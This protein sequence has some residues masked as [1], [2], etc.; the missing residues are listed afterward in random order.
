MCFYFYN[1]Q[2]QRRYVPPEKD[3]SVYIS[4]LKIIAHPHL[5]Q[6]KQLY[7]ILLQLVRIK[8]RYSQCRSAIKKSFAYVLCC[9]SEYTNCWRSSCYKKKP[10]SVEL[11]LKCLPASKNFRR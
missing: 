1:C 8:H 11:F 10:L 3:R 5:M 6:E 9:W 4:F 7:L 2:L